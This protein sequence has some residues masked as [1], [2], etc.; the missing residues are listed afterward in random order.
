M[1]DVIYHIH[2]PQLARHVWLVEPPTKKT[3]CWST[4][5]E[6]LSFHCPQFSSIPWLSWPL[7]LLSGDKGIFFRWGRFR[8]V[9]PGPC[10][11]CFPPRAIVLDPRWPPNL[12]FFILNNWGRWSVVH[13]K[14]PVKIHANSGTSGPCSRHFICSV[15]RLSLILAST[16]AVYSCRITLLCQSR[17]PTYAISRICRIRSGSDPCLVETL[18]QRIRLIQSPIPVRRAPD[19]SW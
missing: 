13:V 3:S 8:E 6:I 12:L 11:F 16:R 4:I 5:K 1:R 10:L 18:S 19:A 9:Q 15:T 14:M 17:N 2:V 7:G